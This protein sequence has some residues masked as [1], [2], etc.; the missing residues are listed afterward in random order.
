MFQDILFFPV[1]LWKRLCCLFVCI[2]FISLVVPA[3]KPG[4]LTGKVSDASTNETLAGVS[5]SAKGT[6]YGIATITDGTY[7]LGLPAGTYTMRF[8]YTGHKTKEITGVVIKAGETTFLDILL[9]AATKQLEGVVVT[10]SIKKEAQSAVYSAQKRSAAVS[11]GISQ[12]AIRKT[13]DNN[14]AQVLTRVTG[15]NVQD[16]RFVVVRGLGDRYNQTM[17]N[18]VPMTSTET[19][20]NA[21]AFDLIPASVIENVVVNKTATPDMPGNFAGGVVQVNTKDFPESNFFSV[22][23]QG[24]FSDGTINKDF[25]S[26]PRGK[27]EWLGFGGDFRDLP[28]NFPSSTSRVRLTEMNYQEQLRY[29]SMLKNTLI[30]KN[31]GSSKPNEQIQLGYGKTIKFKSGTQLG[32]VVAVS[33]RKSELIEQETSVRRPFF[34]FQNPPGTVLPPGPPPLAD[35]LQGFGLTSSNTRYSLFANTGVALNL[36]YRFGNNKITLKNIYSSI[37]R[38]L[39]VE[40]IIGYLKGFDMA[41]TVYPNALYGMSFFPEQKVILNS[42]LGGEHRTGKSNETRLD[43]NVSYTRN[44][45][46][47]PDTRN[48]VL[49]YDTVSRLFSTNYNADLEQSLAQ[50][51]RSWARATDDIYGGAF[52]VTTPFNLFKNKQLFKAGV[53]YQNRMRKATGTI[54]PVGTQGVVSPDSLLVP[55][56]N[57]VLLA[58]GAYAGN[59]G[60]YNAGSSLLAAYESLENKIG[61]K[62]RVIWGLRVEDYQQSVNVYQTVFNYNFTEPDLVPI[63]LAA[64][65]TFNFLPS[66]NVV[67]SPLPSIN[68]RGAYSKTV[69]RPELRD[70]APYA[71]Y[72]FV[73]FVQIQGNEDLKSTGI[74]NYDLKLEWFP[75]SGEILSVAAFYKSIRDPIEYATTTLERTEVRI[76][77]NTGTAFVKGIEGEIRKKLD[78][79]TF[80][81]WLSHV[82]VF[83]NGTLLRSKVKGKNINSFQLSSFSEHP[84]T[85]QAN[86]IANAGVSIL[87]FKDNFETTFSY[88]KTGDYINDLGASDLDVHLAN[89]NVIPT[90]P[91][92]RVRPRDMVDVVANY[93]FLKRKAQLKFKITNLFK[94]PYTLYQDLNG[95]GR[96]DSP[97]TVNVGKKPN[98]NEAYYE[99]NNYHNG[100]DNAASYILGQRTYS[101]SLSYTF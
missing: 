24:G 27:Y 83:G 67:Y 74:T 81:P 19:N 64:R 20:K 2:F 7:I 30:R 62:V 21:F 54:L 13:P 26:D 49:A 93:S 101:L 29:L 92:F 23:L 6:K 68:L 8:S 55:G 14:A 75:S 9:E 98:A 94:E 53:L 79:I 61:Q 58:T 60:N 5:I 1:R 70:L 57:T 39:F 31:Y 36:A 32:I 76:A 34:G 46:N 59:G 3:Q 42:I 38:N 71:S 66:V 99:N 100:I 12:E 78:F 17:V 11:D 43:W 40:R 15:I 4:K 25:I 37:F 96:F 28:K 63:K 65:T 82:Q 22:A 85:G 35:T 88:N 52:N 91:H 84:L 18:G 73:S 86:Y 97:V 47:T 90:N 56:N 69:I 95:N 89:G 77:Y 33:Q 87:L 16:N 80:A 45:T 44:T 51:S 48:F 10:A 72:D 50:Y 41:P